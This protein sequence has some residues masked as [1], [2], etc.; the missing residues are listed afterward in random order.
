VVRSGFVHEPSTS[1][2]ARFAAPDGTS[3]AV[4]TSE[5]KMREIVGKWVLGSATGAVAL[6]RVPAELGVAV[7]ARAVADFHP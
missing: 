2:A 4:G 6:P 3:G 1:H 5:G 7:S